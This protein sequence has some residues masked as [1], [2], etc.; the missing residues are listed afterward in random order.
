MH[1]KNSSDKIWVCFWIPM[2]NSTNSYVKIS[3]CPDFWHLITLQ[4]CWFIVH[5]STH[6]QYQCKTFYRHSKGCIWCNLWYL[7]GG[8]RPNFSLYKSYARIFDICWYKWG[9]GRSLVS[10]IWSVVEGSLCRLIVRNQYVP[11]VGIELVLMSTK[12]I[13]FAR[14]A[15]QKKSRKHLRSVV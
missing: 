8:R 6:T 1:N 13:F 2:Y 12:T 5:C 15:R 9:F 14:T 10:K 11:T 3:E 7:V 4:K